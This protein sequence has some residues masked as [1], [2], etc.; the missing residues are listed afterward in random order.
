MAQSPPLSLVPR[1]RSDVQEAVTCPSCHTTDLTLTAAVVSGGARWQCQR[2]LQ[3]W[4]ASRLATAA[5]YGLWNRERASL[6]PIASAAGV[7]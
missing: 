1:V 3:Q 4:D 7:K 2:C 5:A 6:A